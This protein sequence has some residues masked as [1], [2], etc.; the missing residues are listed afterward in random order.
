MGTTTE[1]TTKIA[2]DPSQSK[3]TVADQRIHWAAP[4][5]T[6]KAAEL[7][8]QFEA[9]RARNWIT[10]RMVEQYQKHW[11]CSREVALERLLA[12]AGS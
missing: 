8:A 11:H 3:P 5:T 7:E 9:M 12:K 10:D 1:T 6:G 2:E 4:T